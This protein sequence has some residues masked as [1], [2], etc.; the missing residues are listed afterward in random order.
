MILNIIPLWAVY[1]LMAALVST[2]IPLLQEKNKADPFSLAIIVKVVSAIVIL[3]SVL[4]QG[5]P[6]NFNF[7]LAVS[8][9]S[10]LWAI[11]DVIYY[12]SVAKVGAGVVSRL[13][14]VSVIL[15]FLLWFI[16]DPSLLDRYLEKPIQAGLIAIIILCSS[17]FAMQLCKCPVS[18][19][20][21]RLIWFVIFAACTGPL[22]EKITLGQAPAA[23]APYAFVFI[24]ACFMVSFW[25]IFLLL[26]QPLS[27]SKLKS[28]LSLKTGV[29]IGL[30]SALAVTLRF[31]GLQEAEHPAYLSVILF[32][33]ALWIVLFHRLIGQNDGSNI[34]AG[35]GIVFC[36]IALVIV[37][38]P[39]LE[40]LF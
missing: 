28:S 5:F 23:Q 20:G 19:R 18:W 4:H 11:S 16:F 30:C 29:V 32:T 22:L 13:L 37:K 1:G 38:S 21:F 15:S 39:L 27:F 26:R 9:T 12:R 31:M 24:Q 6:G 35:I 3:P 40:D 8:L 7:Y 34:K 14:P 2:V 33:D 17:F 36:A 10:L 25:L